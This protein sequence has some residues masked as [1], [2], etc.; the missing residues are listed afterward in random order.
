MLSSVSFSFP[1]LYQSVCS[2]SKWT[3]LLPHALSVYFKGC[4]IQQKFSLWIKIH[5]STTPEEQRRRT[6][7]MMGKKRKSTRQGQISDLPVVTNQTPRLYCDSLINSTHMIINSGEDIVYEFTLL[8]LKSD[9]TISQ[10][11][12]WQTLSVPKV[13]HRQKVFWWCISDRSRTTH[14]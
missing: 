12:C 3:W 7:E 8:S 14:L 4:W 9:V 10:H 11:W 1:C 2:D 5:H 13:W 6:H